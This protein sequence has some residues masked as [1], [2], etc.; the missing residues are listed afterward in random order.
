MPADNTNANAVVQPQPS[1]FDSLKTD[2]N[3]SAFREFPMNCGNNVLKMNADGPAKS[4]L[5][6]ADKMSA[7]ELK[8]ALQREP[9]I[10]SHSS[11]PD[12]LKSDRNMCAFQDIT[13]G[14]GSDALN[15]NTE[16][17][18][19]RVSSLAD[20][21]SCDDLNLV[22]GKERFLENANMDIELMPGALTLGNE[23]S[24]FY[25]VVC[26]FIYLHKNKYL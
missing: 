2:R 3:T 11:S 23:F 6:L 25:L 16:D 21:M 12:S 17:P 8:P 26:F 10:R 14:Y 24:V 13:L 15:V 20:K 5:S 7:D 4:I 22:V 19:Q 1:S 9:L 18:A